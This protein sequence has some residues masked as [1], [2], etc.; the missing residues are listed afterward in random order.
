MSKLALFSMERRRRRGDLIEIYKIMRGIDK[1]N[2][3][4]LFPRAE[5]TITRRHKFKIEDI[6]KVTLG[7]LCAILVTLL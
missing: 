2:S 3:W 1:V 5:M 6:G 7:I 4:K